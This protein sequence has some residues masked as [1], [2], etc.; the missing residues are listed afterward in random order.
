MF[1]VAAWLTLL[2]HEGSHALMA[3]KQGGTIVSFRPWPH[4]D[5]GKW[6]FGAVQWLQPPSSS[7]TRWLYGAPLLFN[8]PLAIGL[9]IGAIWWPPLIIWATWE[10]IDHIWW[11]RGY[12]AI[13]IPFT[14]RWSQPVERLDGQKFRNF[15]Q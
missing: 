6:W 3:R 5:R 12:F 13:S 10:L 2:I 7:Q 4:R 11:W 8:T 9:A 1:V 15:E 14:K